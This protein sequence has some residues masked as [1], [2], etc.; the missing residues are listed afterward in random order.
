MSRGP[1]LLKSGASIRESGKKKQTA[2]FLVSK[3]AIDYKVRAF[4]L[5]AALV[6]YAPP[7]NDTGAETVCS[8]RKEAPSNDVTFLD[9]PS[10]PPHRRH[11][12]LRR[13]DARVWKLHRRGALH[14]QQLCGLL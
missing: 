11:R 5:L 10:N 1:A 8:I 9:S 6:V 3:N 13:H 14:A 2:M 4:D 7:A 12:A